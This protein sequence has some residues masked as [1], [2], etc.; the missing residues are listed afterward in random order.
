MLIIKSISALILFLLCS[1]LYANNLCQS[2]EVVAFSCDIRSKS[3]SVCVA[4]EDNLVYRFGKMNA[5]ELTL[6]SPVFFSSTG[7]SG[8]GEGRLRFPNGRYDYVV[9]SGITNGEW[10]D[11]ATGLREKVEF[12]GILVL[13]D[14]H[15]LSDLKCTAFDDKSFIHDIPQ[16]KQEPFVHY[17]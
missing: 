16:H 11:K 9:Y 4:D 6:H 8:G 10:L 17:D 2:G 1:S 14:K 12:A 5:T 15:L 13:K 3:V 7:Y